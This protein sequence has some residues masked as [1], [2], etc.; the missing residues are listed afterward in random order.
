MLPFGEYILG[1]IVPASTELFVRLQLGVSTWHVTAAGR[2]EYWPSFQL[3]AFVMPSYKPQVI[4]LTTCW[5]HCQICTFLGRAH[6]Q[7]RLSESELAS[8]QPTLPGKMS[9][10]LWAPKAMSV[11][12]RA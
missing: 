10:R 6:E 4:K 11:L 7:A 1:P 12:R 9:A 3:R 8:S 5:I 2:L